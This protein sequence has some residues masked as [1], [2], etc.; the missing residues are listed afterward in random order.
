V[1]DNPAGHTIEAAVGTGAFVSGAS[2]VTIRNLVVQEFATATSAGAIW[3]NYDWD[4]ENN[5][6]RLNHGIGILAGG[7][8]RNNYVH[9][10]GQCGISTI[11]ATSML[12]ENNEIAYNNY[13]GYDTHY[14]GGG[15]KFV[16]S[17]N[18]IVR[19]NFVHN[20]Y[21][22]GIWFDWDNKGI[23]VA[24]NT[25]TNND[26]PG[27]FHEAGYDAVFRNN[28]VRGNGFHFHSG[29][30]DGSGILLLASN[31]TQIYGNIVQKNEHGIGITQTNRGVGAFGPHKTHDVYVHDNVVSTVARGIAA[32]F[33]QSGRDPRYYTSRDIRFANN[34]YTT[35]G[36]VSFAWA[37]GT[38]GQPYISAKNWVE[39]GND[40][41]GTFKIAC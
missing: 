19:G 2:G 23:L 41:T 6:V 30:I 24:N 1:G 28:I 15:T 36:T 37:R 3:A 40:R 8:V 32:G 18:V 25:I 31:D 11:S 10:N 7:T 9:D 12:V 17:R 29:W 38:N 26:G 33:V 14:D 20:N 4:I 34:H 22:T 21:G 39:D 35:C 16:K 5:E 27:I 13:A